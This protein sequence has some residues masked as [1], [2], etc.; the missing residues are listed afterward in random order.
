M[1]DI[2]P[3]PK[4]RLTPLSIFV[5]PRPLIKDFST[6]LLST[7]SC[8]AQAISDN[9]SKL[10]IQAQFDP[11]SGFRFSARSFA[12]YI[13]S[14]LAMK[15]GKAWQPAI[16]QT[17]HTHIF[18]SLRHSEVQENS[19]QAL[20]EQVTRIDHAFLTTLAKV[21]I[22]TV[23]LGTSRYLRLKSNGQVIN[24][25]E[26]IDKAD[27]DIV[28]PTMDEVVHDIRTIY[29]G[30]RQLTRE[31]TH[32]V[33]TIS[34]QRYGWTR[35]GDFREKTDF[36][37]PLR[38]FPEDGAVANCYDKSLLRVCLQHTLDSLENDPRCLYFPSFEMVLD[39]LR[40]LENM[41]IKEGDYGHV[42]QDTSGYVTN[43]FANLYFSD[44]M[45]SF[46]RD[47]R[48]KEFLTQ[49]F[50]F[51]TLQDH[52][53]LL[54]YYLDLFDSHKGIGVPALFRQ[55]IADNFAKFVP[56]FEPTKQ[57][58]LRQKLT[59]LYDSENPASP[60]QRLIARVNQI[61]LDKRILVFGMGETAIALLQ[62]SRLTAAPDLTFTQSR[63]TGM[64]NYFG[65]PVLPL[66]EAQRQEWDYVIIASVGSIEQIKELLSKFSKKEVI[67][68]TG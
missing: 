15:A 6:T 7:G 40:A 61:D 14:L 30:L 36:A 9:L 47:Y 35:M 41:G 28:T 42:S 59:A 68:G 22:V 10:G 13:E 49:R 5:E 52:D 1:L 17:A 58:A 3:G 62:Q 16:Y 24:N 51:Q 29:Q 25:Y 32:L 12:D 50:N 45:K 67:T 11:R 2:I 34:P 56:F 19:A 48:Q 60:V 66:D 4:R 8:F 65:K 38:P 54:D 33:F 18:R 64:D 21:D 20:S 53:D 55:K 44:A 39:E 27:Y 31:H 26:G 37:H 43:R 46:F 63:F 23:T 57:L